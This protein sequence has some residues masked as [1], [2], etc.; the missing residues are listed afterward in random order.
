MTPKL[1]CIQVNK[2]LIKGKMSK[3]NMATQGMYKTPT[4]YIQI[5]AYL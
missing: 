5:S 3:M 2:L 1:I 4:L